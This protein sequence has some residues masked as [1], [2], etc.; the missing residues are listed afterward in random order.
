MLLI[1][2]ADA[3]DDPARA[4]SDLFSGNVTNIHAV[5]AG[6][7]DA[8]RS[9]GHWSVGA[10]RARVGLLLQPDLQ[11]DGMLLGV[12]LPRRPAAAGATRMRLPDRS[13]R[14]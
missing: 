1:D 12:T 9:L 11:S 6:R 8:L 4:L 13:R 7:S 10:R 2:D 3:T 14:L 5:V